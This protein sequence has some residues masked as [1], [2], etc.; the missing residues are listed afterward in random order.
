MY[1]D[2]RGLWVQQIT[3]NGKRRVF[4]AKSKKDLLLKI[5]SYRQ[6]DHTK[7]PLN[8]VADEWIRDIEGRVTFNT[9]KGY[10]A[11]Y[12]K[13]VAFWGDTY[14]EDITAQQITSWLLSFDLA[15]KTLKN[16]LLVFRLIYNYAYVVYN[17]KQNPT[18]HLRAPKGKGKKER[19]FPSE[20]DIRIVNE[21]TDKPFG[22]M[23][24]M[25]LYTG[26]RRGELCALT[27]A[28]IDFDQKLIKVTKSTYWTDDHVPH[29]KT[30]KTASGEREVPLMDSLYDLLKPMQGKP[31]D[32]VFGDLHSYQI[33]KGI[34]KYM[35]ETGCGVTLH[36]LRHGFASILYK[37][38]IDIK[39]AAYVLGHAQ[40]S[41]TLEIYTHL[42]EQDKLRT[43]RMALN[44]I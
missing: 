11:A 28:D 7:T 15:Q 43:V 39:T 25:A 17:V 32:K 42:M 22:L 1:K 4:S 8:K 10:N 31:S 35:D 34:R 9:M 44:E 13:I 12:K 6:E 40:S 33:D 2:K 24:Y 41:T 37:N 23:M 26:L 21:N 30:P 27:W 5:A 18:L 19:E 36:G 16:I 29:T 14:M 38:N 20:E 3:V